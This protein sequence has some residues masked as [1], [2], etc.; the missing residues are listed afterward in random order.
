MVRARPITKVEDLRAWVKG[1][2]SVVEK[3][4]E[5]WLK[6]DE[7]LWE[8]AIGIFRRRSECS[9]ELRRRVEGEQARNRKPVLLLRKLGM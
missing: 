7:K 6:G 8:D 4:E 5:G 2:W 3:I 9:E 1:T